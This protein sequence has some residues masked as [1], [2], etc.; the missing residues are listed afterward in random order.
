VR[1]KARIV[2]GLDVGTYKTCLVLARAHRDGGLEVLAS[3]Y[4]KSR[5]MTKGSVVNLAEVSDSIRRAVKEAA[6]KSNVS[7]NRVVAGISGSHVRSL[8]FRGAV[9][10]E[11]KHGEVTPRDM[12]NAIYAAKAIPIPPESEIIHLLPQEFILNSQGGIKNPLGLVG[13]QLDVNLHVITCNGAMIQS[14]INA[15]NKAQIEVKRVILQSIASGEAVLTPEEKELG[16]A[17]IDIGGGTTGIA[18]FLKNSICFVSVIPAGGEHFTRDLVAGLRISRE[19]AER[20][21]IE[22]GNV[23]PELIAPDEVVDVQGLGTRG[24]SSVA[25]TE[26]CGYLHD[27]GAE[28]LEIIK[29]AVSRFSGNLIGG[30]VLTGGG[31]LMKGMPEL[32]ELILEMP[33]RVGFARDLSGST[34]G[35]GHP[36]YACAMGLAIL[37]AQ[38]SILQD[39]QNKTITKPT[40]MDRILRCF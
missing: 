19:E 14:L 26:I 32:A 30:A 38:E 34:N 16:T 29:D 28:L 36:A 5:G 6:S 7:V 18:V 33:V 22:S 24:S 17:V 37:E 25:R 23:V 3:G 31:S 4:A 13:S 20:I 2:C 1:R 10:V 39:L 12:Q 9:P 8:I 21:K 11:G 15:A 40:M 35:L 27:R